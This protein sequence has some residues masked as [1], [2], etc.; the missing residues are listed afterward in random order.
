VKSQV[1]SVTAEQLVRLQD[2]GV[3]ASYLQ[4][5]IKGRTIEEVI[6]MHDRGGNME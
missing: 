4:S 3:S 2:H 1:P 6:R 5:N